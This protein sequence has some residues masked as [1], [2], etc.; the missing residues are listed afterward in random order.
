M[1]AVDV[2]EVEPHP[3]AFRHDLGPRRSPR[4]VDRGG[5]QPEVGRSVVGEDQQSVL[6]VVDRVL[7][8]V[9]PRFDQHGLRLGRIAGQEA[10]LARD[11]AGG[12]DEDVPLALRELDVDLETLVVLLEHEHVRLRRRAEPVPPHLVGPHRLV[13]PHVEEGLAVGGPGRAVVDAGDHVGQVG[14]GAQVTEPQCVQL[15]PVHVRGVGDLGFVRA[16]LHVA[17]L[18]V[19]VP[20]CQLVAVEHELLGRL[21]RAAAPA[22]DLVVEP[23]HRPRVAP[24][25]LVEGG[26]RGVRL[27]DAPD[28]LPVEAFLEPAGFRH[29]GRGVGVLGL[30]VRD[31]LGVLPVAEP[32]VGIDPPVAVDLENLR[33]RSGHGRPERGDLHRLHDRD[34]PGATRRAA[35]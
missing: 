11:V 8:V 34:R 16:P 32:V 10:T 5:H 3:R 14:R 1:A 2:G 35:A 15:R 29:D 25:A 24:P 12:A 28:D 20:L 13:R 9:P 23:F 26:C 21:H 19:G 30:Q 17:Q 27:L 33:T 31:H 6:L 7:D 4:A 18:E 22:V